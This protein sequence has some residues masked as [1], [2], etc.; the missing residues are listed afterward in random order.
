M[1]QLSESQVLEKIQHLVPFEAQLD[2]GSLTIRIS[3][4]Q[5]YIA[6][7]IHHGHNLREELLAKCALSEEERY[8]EEDPFTGDFITSLP[9]ILQG[10]DSRYEYDLNRAPDNCIYEDAWGKEVWTEN[11]TE[12]ERQTT[13]E[14]H[15]RYYRILKCLI[16]TLENKFGLCLLYDI[17]S[18][19]YQRIERE[20]PTFNLGTEQV[21]CRRW[22]K[23]LDVLLEHLNAIELPNIDVVA[24][25][26]DVFKGMGYQAT[27]VKENFSNTLIMPLEVKKV[28]MNEQAGDAYPLVID[29]LKESMKTAITE[30]AAFTINKRTKAKGLTSSDLL[31]S[32]LSKEAIKLDRQLYKIARGLNTLSYINPTNLKQEKRRFL[33]K[34]HT[35]VPQF[36]YRQLDLDPY[37]FREQLYRLPVEDIRDADVQKMY[38]RVIDQLAV[39]IDLL[40]TIGTDE[41]LYNSLRYYGQPDERDIANAKFILHA[42]EYAKQE[43]ATINAAGAIQA[44]K[45]AAADYGLPCKIVMSKQLI[46]RALVSGKTVKVNPNSTFSKPDLEALIHHELGVHLVTSVNAERQPLRVLQLGLPGNTHTQ[47]GLAILCEHLSGNFPLHRLK[48]LALRVV[49]VDMMV[50]GESFNDTF[51]TLKHDYDVSDDEA[52]TVTARAYRGGGFTKDYLYLRGLKDAIKAYQ[53]EDLTSLFI[54]KTGFEFKPV[55]DELIERGILK[56]PEFLP[57]ALS[58]NAELDPVMEFMLSSIR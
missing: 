33:S 26:N 53:E 47:E 50:N 15:A 44:F 32:S 11:L 13:L 54:G 36:T 39:R 48:T 7:A 35:Y 8:F 57:K 21:N 38:R 1:L 23:E 19:N 6:T 37:K 45:E 30:H 46:A 3:E 16:E 5:P 20:V 40:C 41:F 24:N 52:F 14:K 31:A 9:I 51:N 58:M 4:Y 2:D 22:R 18:Y 28:F 12:Q 56:Q 25:E 49:A 42:C 34:P 55:L 17:H 43:E 29:K 27:F 10:E